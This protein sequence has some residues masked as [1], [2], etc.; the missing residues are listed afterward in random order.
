MN[1]LDLFS[2]IGGFALAARWAGMETIGFCEKD[3]FCQQV[4]RKHWPMVSIAC[5]IKTFSYHGEVDILTAGFPC[6]PFSV[7]GKKKGVKEE[8]NFVENR[9]HDNILS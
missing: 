7:A 1:H 3:E 2:G 6:Q 9:N 4:L 5:D 8:F